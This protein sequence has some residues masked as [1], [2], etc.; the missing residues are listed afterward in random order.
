MKYFNLLFDSNIEN[1]KEHIFNTLTA[2][3]VDGIK[4]IDINNFEIIQLAQF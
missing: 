3:K 2:N 4:M 1:E